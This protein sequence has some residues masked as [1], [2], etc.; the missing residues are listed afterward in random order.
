MTQ[1]YLT[2][3]NQ[4]VSKPNVRKIQGQKVIVLDKFKVD[5][6]LF[7]RVHSQLKAIRPNL[8]REACY[9]FEDLMGAGFLQTLSKTETRLAE[10]CLEHLAQDQECDLLITF[11]EDPSSRYMCNGE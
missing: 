3:F 2:S 5:E 7:D 4:D 9:G 8:L 1:P 10:F 6:N 11:A